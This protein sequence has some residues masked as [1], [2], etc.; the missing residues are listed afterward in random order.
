LHR[1]GVLL[2]IALVH[3]GAADESA[4][5]FWVCVLAVPSIHHP[6]AAPWRA[7]NRSSKKLKGLL[8]GPKWRWSLIY[9]VCPIKEM[10]ICDRR[11]PANVCLQVTKK[12]LD[13]RLGQ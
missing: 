12:H 1:C 3:F 7:S 13:A 8:N 9:K 2:M 11:K 4:K 6:M 10:T 5:S